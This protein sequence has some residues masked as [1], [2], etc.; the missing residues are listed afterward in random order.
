M[1]IILTVILFLLGAFSL[2]S[3]KKEEIANINLVL[4]VEFADTAS[5]FSAEDDTAIKSVFN[6]D[7]GLDN[8]ISLN[9]NQRHL[10]KSRILGVV[11][12]DKKIDYFMPKY[13]YDILAGE[14]KEINAEGYDNRLYD[15]NG[16]PSTSGK[17]SADRFFREQE[18][19]YYSTLKASELTKDLGKNPEFENLTLVPSRLNRMVGEGDLFHPHQTNNYVGEASSLSEVYYTEG[20]EG[21]I[22][23]AKIGKT[24]VGSY[25]LI[26]YAYM[27]DGE[28][29]NVTTLCHEYMH[30]LGLPD[31]YSGKGIN[32][33]KPVGEFDVMGGER[34]DI[35][36]QSLSYVKY[37][38]GW[39]EEGKD[40]LPITGSGEYELTALEDEGGVKAYKITLGDY[41]EKG[42]VFYIEYRKLGKGS[43]NKSAKDGVIIY[44]VNQANGYISSSGERSTTWR[45]NAYGDYEIIVFRNP[46][47]FL[48]GEHPTLTLEDGYMSYGN[49][50][51]SVNVIFNSD[52][53]NSNIYVEFLSVSQDGKA[54]IKVEI[55]DDKID[56]PREKIG[57]ELQEGNR[58][59]VYFDRVDSKTKAYVYHSDKRVKNPTA[60]KLLNSKK[61]ELIYSHTTF[62]K[63]TLPHTHGLEKYVYVFYEYENGYSEVT[64]YKIQG[65]K[66]LKIS[67]VLIFAVGM[68]IFFPTV[69]L[70]LISKISK[71]KEKSNE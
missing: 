3:C 25:V 55:P 48:F 32:V 7:G 45:G 22:K 37:K 53:T 11:K 39:L 64:E 14:Y 58:Y 1:T 46:M 62:L 27:F 42:D 26:P 50:G 23:E 17:Q 71:K 65:I 10:T 68:G 52:Q 29:I 18:L 59:A 28:E 70:R 57:L 44:R 16:L 2:T 40:I 8:F 49:P 34:T 56:V 43:L 13:E 61:G 21:A 63:A 47:D 15:E 4:M 51:G 33:K 41:Y 20:V 60:E 5:P 69:A 67:A 36:T 66:N 30:V 12:I 19:L 38:M 54:K 35:P 24:T 6:G 31:L 9:S